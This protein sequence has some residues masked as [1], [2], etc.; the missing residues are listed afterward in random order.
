MMLNTHTDTLNKD[1]L[2][3]SK[4]SDIGCVN[5]L[6]LHLLIEKSLYWTNII[7]LRH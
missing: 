6:K 3:Y 7:I 2:Q 4:T 5:M 1:I